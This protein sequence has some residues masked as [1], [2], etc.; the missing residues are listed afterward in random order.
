MSPR[1]NNTLHPQAGLTPKL[2]LRLPSSCKSSSHFTPH[3]CTSNSES[4]PKLYFQLS[5]PSKT[6]SPAV[7]PIKITTPAVAP[8]Q[9][10]D[11]SGQSTKKR[12]ATPELYPQLPLHP[13]TV[14][15]TVIRFHNCISNCHFAPTLEFQLS[16]HPKSC[17][18][19][20]HATPKQV[21]R[22]TKDKLIPT[23]ICGLFC[24]ILPHP[25][26]VQ[27]TTQDKPAVH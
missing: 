4:T 23:S 20:F 25:R 11:S 9:Y 7:L 17:N 19:K 22:N 27:Y 2:W 1:R 16:V 12:K 15:A 10:C 21:Q 18:S 3:S 26:Q 8:P 24:N 5:F 6:A 14:L 13:N